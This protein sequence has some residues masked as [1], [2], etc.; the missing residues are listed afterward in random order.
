MAK[1]A[2]GTI[3]DAIDEVMRKARSSEVS[4]AEVHGKVV[5]KVGHE[6]PKSSVRSSL[7]LRSNQYV[8]TRRGYYRLASR[9]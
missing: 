9:G 8:Q 4:V 6:V 5:Q 1:L 3:R 2:P 7:R